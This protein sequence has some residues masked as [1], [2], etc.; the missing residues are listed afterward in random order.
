MSLEDY[1]EIKKYGHIINKKLQNKPIYVL[2]TTKK[3]YQRKNCPKDRFEIVRDVEYTGKPRNFNDTLVEL[4]KSLGVDV[5][6]VETNS[7]E[8]HKKARECLRKFKCHQPDNMYLAFA[9]VTG[10]DVLTLDG[11]VIF[12]S[13]KAKVKSIDFHEF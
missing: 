5:Y 12:S 4:Q 10:S 8:L 6:Y 11:G 2:D 1:Q 3:E 9:I 7:S 13:K